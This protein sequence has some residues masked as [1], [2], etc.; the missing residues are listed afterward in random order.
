MGACISTHKK[1]IKI[2]NG[3]KM[4]K[5]ATYNINLLDSANINEN[6]DNII[7]Y[8]FPENNS[9]IDILCLQNIH[10]NKVLQILLSTL[11]EKSKKINTSLYFSPE[12]D[13]KVHDNSFESSFE[14][15]WSSSNN[16]K[17][18]AIKNIIISR[19]PIFSSANVK[20][21]SEEEDSLFGPRFM[22]IANIIIDKKIISVYNISLIEDIMG[23]NNKDIRQI[24]VDNVKQYVDENKNKLLTSSELKKL[25]YTFDDI[26]LI[27]GAFNIPE[28]KNNKINIELINTFKQL[29]CVD[30][31][32]FLHKEDKGNTSIYGTRECF[33][34]VLVFSPNNDVYTNSNELFK[35][36]LAEYGVGFI[37]T[38]VIRNLITT[39]YYPIECLMIINF[40][41]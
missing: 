20:I 12:I 37:D 28:M 32:R 30:I 24:E 33:N 3:Y 7:S 22:V 5:I 21:S 17:S 14:M 36:I 9:V 34:T 8:I 25:N 1:Q 16:T 39:E 2:P 41:K 26:H 11:L 10:D 40:S 18:E 4:L 23:F 6:L 19:F 31:F 13:L 29:K 35:F 27:C 38:K 15:T